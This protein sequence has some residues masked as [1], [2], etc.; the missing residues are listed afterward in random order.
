VK[1]QPRFYITVWLNGHRVLSE[2]VMHALPDAEFY[3]VFAAVTNEYVRRERAR[4]KIEHLA[5]K[6]ALSTMV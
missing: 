3:G 1:E 2:R 4:A 6:L 5:D